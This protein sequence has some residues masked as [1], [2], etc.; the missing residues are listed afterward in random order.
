MI[1]TS[2]YGT[3]AEANDYFDNR[4]HEKYW[5]SASPSDQI[6]AL[7][8]A[9]QIIDT[10]S[11]KGDKASVA[12]F[13]NSTPRQQWTDDGIRAADAAQELEFPRGTGESPND[14]LG[15]G[16]TP[17]FSDI[18]LQAIDAE[19]DDLELPD[20][21]VPEPIRRAC[22]EIAYSLL[23]GKCPERELENLGVS[24]H[25][26]EGVRTSYDRGMLPVEHTVNGVPSAI[27]WRLI[28]PYLR[29]DNTIRMSRV[30]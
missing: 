13:K 26:F 15:I 14:R 29:D 9:T 16:V 1:P 10:L 21:T 8:A 12:N 22:Y 25:G 11:F 18:D 17:D 20:T 6:K 30:S 2:Y 3:Q 5:S 4:L 7:R 23:S 27:A 24:S 28:Q 19:E